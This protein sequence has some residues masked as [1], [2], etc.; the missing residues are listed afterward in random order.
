MDRT[1]HLLSEMVQI[2]SVNPREGSAPA[3]EAMANFVA[4]WLD[5]AGLQVSVE[6]VLPGRPNVIAR[7][8]GRDGSKALLLEGHM[9]TVEVDGMT[10]PPFEGTV[11]DGRLYGRGSADAKG[12]LA[13]FML[14]V[15]DLAARHV[16]PPNDI[17][18][19]AVADEE[20][21]FRGVLHLLD[22][23]GP[24][25]AAVVGEPTRLRMITAHKG[26]LRFAVRTVGRSAH[27]SQPWDGQNAIDSM[28]DVAL[29]L[30]NTLA[31]EAAERVHP[32]LGSATL[33][34]AVI[35]GGTAINVV[36]SSCVLLLDRRTLPDE[37]PAAVWAVYRDRIEGLAP[38]R[39]RVEQPALT[40]QA[41]DTPGDSPLVLTMADVL[42]RH[43][44]EPAPT[45]AN[46]GSDASKLCGHGIPSV[47]FGP[48][49]IGDA[50]SANES[51]EVSE[52]RTATAVVTDLLTSLT[53]LGPPPLR[54]ETTIHTG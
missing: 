53:A 52:V 42:R 51:I 35:E 12:P 44:L 47:V 28:I 22:S 5:D 1:M 7:L 29:F 15:G 46:Y 34:P 40:S 31:P 49:S 32:L 13:A 4:T 10:V 19:A 43:G 24:L 17:L 48:G 9:D 23:H 14:A 45:G 54:N 18:L 2:P 39:I 26:C 3:E 25:S 20:H 38:D 36:P 41:L 50:H 11:R 30:R 8:P 6:E 27:S 21:R 16:V 33:C 37:D